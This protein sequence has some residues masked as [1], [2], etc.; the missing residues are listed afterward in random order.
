MTVAAGF[1]LQSK[2]TWK[3]PLAPAYVHMHVDDQQITPQSL[4]IADRSQ[5]MGGF[6]A[7]LN[8]QDVSIQYL[9]LIAMMRMC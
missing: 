6:L 9:L 7:I 8:D 4:N 3:L 2:R 1:K 5:L